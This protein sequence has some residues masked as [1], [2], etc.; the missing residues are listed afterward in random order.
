MECVKRGC[1]ITR[2]LPKAKFIKSDKVFKKVITLPS[3]EKVEIEYK[4]KYEKG[5]KITYK[6]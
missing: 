1:D 6:M 4:N 5:D 3:G 2:E